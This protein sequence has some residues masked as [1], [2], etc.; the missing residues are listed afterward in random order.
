[1]RFLSISPRVKATVSVITSLTSSGS[2]RMALFFTITDPVDDIADASAVLDNI[3]KGFGDLVRI[4]RLGPQ[5]P[6]GGMRVGDKRADGLIDLVRDRGGQL[7]D[8]GDPIGVRKL[9]LCVEP[10]LFGLLTFGHV[11]VGTYDLDDIVRCVKTGC[12]TL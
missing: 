5:K 8:G 3:V 7:T 10:R 12:A 4:R 1:M 9:V 2:R 11:D 6:Q